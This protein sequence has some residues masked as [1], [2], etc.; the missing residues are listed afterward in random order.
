MAD[1][2]AAAGSHPF[3]VADLEQIAVAAYNCSLMVE[4]VKCDPFQVVEAQSPVEE[5]AAYLFLNQ[6]NY[7]IKRT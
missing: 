3:L 7:T 6:T 1:I 4:V 2:V 5:S